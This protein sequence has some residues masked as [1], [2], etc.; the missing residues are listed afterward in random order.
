MHQLAGIDL[1]A[2]PKDNLPRYRRLYRQLREAILNG[3]IIA[4]ERLPSS[5]GLS[6]QLH[7]SRNTVK[8]ALELLQAEGYIH[9]RHGA[10][11]FVEENIPDSPLKKTIRN[12]C[13][14]SQSTSVSEPKLSALAHQINRKSPFQQIEIDRPLTPGRPAL[15]HFPWHLWRRCCSQAARQTRSAP[16]GFLP[17]QQQLC[18]YLRQS[19]GL[20]CEPEQVHIFSGSQHALHCAFS[21]LL[22][23]SDPVLVEDPGFPG[24]DGAL[25]ALG[26]NAIPCPVD[27]SGIQIPDNSPSR[28]AIVTPSRNYPLGH[29]LSLERRLHL[30]RWAEQVNGWIIEDDYDSEFRYQGAPLTALQGLDNHQRV[31]YSG[32]LSRIMF[33]GI[34]LGYLIVPP[35][36]V[37]LFQQA[38]RYL[39]GGTSV[40]A[41]AALSEFM[42]RGYFA[43]HLRRMRKL[44]QTRQQHL[45]QQ[46][47]KTFSRVFQHLPSDGGMHSIYLSGDRADRPICTLAQQSGLGIQPLSPYYQGSHTLQGL[48]V[49]FAGFDTPVISDAVTKLS[50][51]LKGS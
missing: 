15:D 19:R 6:E 20:N 38:R 9:T 1:Q 28:M 32:T 33:P 35:S 13:R 25:Q 26:A 2:P 45:H 23:P 47:N 29:T 3:Q 36:L 37:E 5:R 18:N 41:Q 34:R 50:H 8:A 51:L 12:P 42:S 44:Y 49:G 40:V 21:L 48:I 14:D 43:S 4:G 24:I 11:T 46:M 10:G 39:D 17:L 30:L 31:I 7:V 27:S 16:A 22:D